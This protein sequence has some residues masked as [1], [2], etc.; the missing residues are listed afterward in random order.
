MTDFLLT[1]NMLAWEQ[2]QLNPKLMIGGSFYRCPKCKN[3]ILVPYGRSIT[4]YKYC[5]NCKEPLEVYKND[6]I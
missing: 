6:R 3:E 2:V 5:N 4:T 1:K